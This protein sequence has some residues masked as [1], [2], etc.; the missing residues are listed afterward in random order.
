MRGSEIGVEFP[1]AAPFSYYPKSMRG[2]APLTNLA[3]YATAGLSSVGV[4]LYQITPT[5]NSL[6][7]LDS[8]GRLSLDG[9]LIVAVIGLWRALQALQKAKDDAIQKK[10]EA[11]AKKD[12]QMVS[13]FV[14]VIDAMVRTSDGGKDV[15][16]AEV[17]AQI[18][19][20][21]RLIAKPERDR[22]GA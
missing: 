16:K 15:M 11:I 3:I 21:R 7:P 13:M 5:V 8:F 14:E 17:A 4:L 22:S 12:E 9:C 6:P 1:D 2:L 18:G 19:S 20:L 10:D